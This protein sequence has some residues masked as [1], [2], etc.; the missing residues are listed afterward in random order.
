MPVGVAKGS[1]PFVL[2][3]AR[4]AALWPKSAPLGLAVSGGGDSLA[5]LH[6]ARAL[7]LHISVA[8]VDHNLREGSR[9]E[10]EFVAALCQSFGIPHKILTWQSWNGRGNLQDQARRA[11]YQLLAQWA[12]SLGLEAIALGHTRDDLAETFLMRLGRSAGLDGLCAM[13]AKRSYLSKIW[14][15][16][17]LEV[18]RVS[19][20][21]FLQTQGHDWLEDPSNDNA[22]F[23]RIR[24]RK[25][26]V[27]L[28][29]LG[30]DSATLAQVAAQLG[31]AR[32]ALAHQTHSFAQDHVQ[33]IGPDVL[34]ER[35]S[36][37]GAPVELLRR[38]LLAAIMWVSSAEYGPRGANLARGIQ[39]LLAGH[40]VPL[41]GC[42]LLV[43]DLNFRV[44]REAKAAS[45][46][47]P[48]T[49]VWDGRWQAFGPNLADLTL[50]PL[51]A[52][53]LL[54]VQSWRES[55]FGR[56]SLLASPALWCR[57][58][59]IAAPFAGMSNNYRVSLIPNQKDFYHSLLPH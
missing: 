17:L 49:Q 45:A 38:S 57:D 52:Q 50:G 1:D 25:A 58:T 55:G 6:L 14:L 20:R 47:V 48:A 21:D 28:D 26:M 51:G 15:R 40:S 35:A 22:K 5:L 37:S 30:L 54:Q 39:A 42:R 27:S 53:G 36:Y 23:D 13:Q 44:T 4:M 31:R 59:L 56:V 29:E 3:A 7:N 19:L 2:F 11:R 43:E 8:T 32:E 41:A 46:P 24:I 9:A 12:E 18:P 33:I 16:P 34:L 10:A